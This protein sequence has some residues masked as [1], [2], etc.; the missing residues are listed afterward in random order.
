MILK[1]RP[2]LFADPKTVWADAFFVVNIQGTSL[3]QQS[4]VRITRTEYQQAS[5]S[6]VFTCQLMPLTNID[7]GSLW[8]PPG[9]TGTSY[10]PTTNQLLLFGVSFLREGGSPINQNDWY[11]QTFASPF[12]VDRIPWSN[13]ATDESGSSGGC[14]AGAFAPYAGVLLLPL[15]AL[16]RRKQ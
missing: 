9:A 1:T 4:G 6:V 12:I 15:L 8:V 13:E 14:S 2:S 3:D 11:S 10:T 5:N 16:V 7:D